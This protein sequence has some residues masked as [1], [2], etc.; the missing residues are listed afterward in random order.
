MSREF[1][2]Y[3]SGYFHEKIESCASDA[4]CGR[5]FLTRLWGRL[6]GELYHVAYAVS[7]SEACDSGPDYPIMESILRMP[8]LKK[9]LD[10]IDQYLEPYRR[11]AENAVRE[12]AKKEGK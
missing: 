12:A 7:T 1:G 6:L 9:S 3:T 4:K 8:E 2:S 11:V 10:E 5:D